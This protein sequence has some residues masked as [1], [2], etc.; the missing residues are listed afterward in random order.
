VQQEEILMEFKA[1][2]QGVI[3]Y[4][5]MALYLLGFILSLLKNEK[6]G[7][8]IFS[9]GFITALIAYVF[10][11]NHVGHWPLQNLFEVFLTLGLIIYPISI[12]CKKY[13]SVNSRGTDMLLGAIILFP[14]G[15]IFNSDPRYL[16]PALQS[17]LFAPHVGFYMFSYVIMAKATVQAAFQLTGSDQASSST[18]EQATYNM[19][20][21]GFPLMTIGL[22]LA[23][24]WA[25]VAWG[26]YWGWDPKELWSLASWLIFVGY[27]H[28]RYMFGKKY[29]Q[30][31][32]IWVITGLT[33]IILTLLWVNLSRLFAGIHNYA[34]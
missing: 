25:R 6:A 3:I 7:D 8:R 2:P 22:I 19:V 24:W 15:F 1:N 20:R 21:L 14:A 34:T 17:W 12:F 11:W 9:I 18:Y 27:L 5:T 29:S 4:I 31:N 28:F 26:D 10:R 30:I 16:P 33:A 32:S 13:L 23:C